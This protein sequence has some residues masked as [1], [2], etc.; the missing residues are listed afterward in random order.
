MI[1]FPDANDSLRTKLTFAAKVI[2]PASRSFAV[3]VKLPATK[4]LRPNMTAILKIA[5]Y[6][7]SGSLVVPLKAIQRSEQGDYVFVNENGTAKRVPVKEGNTYDNQTE[8]LSGLSA[9]QQLIVMGASDVEDGDKI[10]VLQTG[11]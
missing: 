5:D 8:I 7:K 9:G 2:D 10:K 1:L 11:N 3:E 4:T 6:S